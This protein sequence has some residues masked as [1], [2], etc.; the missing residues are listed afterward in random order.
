MWHH[1][2]TKLVTDRWV[3]V[4]CTAGVFG[5][6]GVTY[7]S[8]TVVVCVLCDINRPQSWLLVTG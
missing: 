3:V 1:F 6:P 8:S 4:Y 5:S 2:T 7:V